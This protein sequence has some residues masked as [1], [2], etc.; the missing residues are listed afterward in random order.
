MASTIRNRTDILNLLG[1]NSSKAISAQDVRDAIVSVWGVFGEMYVFGGTTAQVVGTTPT[2]LTLWSSI[3]ES[4]GV[5]VDTSNNRITI[6]AGADGT[7]RV[8][9]NVDYNGD[10]N[11]KFKFV[12]R[13]TGSIISRATQSRQF[14]NTGLDGVRSAGFSGYLTAAVGDQL[15]IYVEATVNSS[16]MTIVEAQFLIERMY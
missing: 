3:G 8:H 15:Q 14:F 7:Y 16:N 2:V 10:H 13:R 12:L 4:N 5:T 6:G 1:D 9:C 11:V